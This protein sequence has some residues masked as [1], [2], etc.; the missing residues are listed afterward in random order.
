MNVQIV[1]FP[2]T[3]V[4]ALEHRGSPDRERESIKKLVQWRIENKF[5][6]SPKHRNY[7][8]HYNDP[9]KVAPADY[10]IDLCISVEHDVEPNVYGIINKIIP[11]CRCAKARHI[12]SRENIP[13]AMYIYEKWLP[14]SGEKAADLPVIFH[15]V[16]IG[17]QI[18]EK[19]M[20]T[21]VYFPLA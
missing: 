13:V 18:Q 2:E 20:I 17:P 16:N 21:D 6:P 11:S 8:L 14:E 10:R 1:Q 3:K 4:A 5:P 9:Y 7:G 15:Y 12:G 19:E